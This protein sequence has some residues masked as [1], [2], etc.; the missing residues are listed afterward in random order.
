MRPFLLAVGAFFMVGCKPANP[1][2]TA[3]VTPVQP[4]QPA[5]AKPNA[6][7]AGEGVTAEAARA[8]GPPAP[9]NLAAALQSGTVH[10]SWMPGSSASKEFRLYR[11]TGADPA[12]FKPVGVVRAT[13]ASPVT[14][15][16]STAAKGTTYTYFVTGVDAFGQ[17]G[18]Y[19]NMV[20][21]EVR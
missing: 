9:M 12:N 7:P 19:S 4:S 10:L 15:D 18:G 20:V 6:E 14:F 8:G 13:A 5:S 11:F 2:R 1:P 21:I 3:V 17:Q 16:D